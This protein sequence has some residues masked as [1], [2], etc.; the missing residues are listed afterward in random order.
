VLTATAN[1]PS[2][3]YFSLGNSFKTSTWRQQWGLS[4]VYV[5]DNQNTLRYA[6]PAATWLT[7]FQPTALNN[8]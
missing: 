7:E 4:W 8:P 6:N 5:S 3:A 2:I 1:V